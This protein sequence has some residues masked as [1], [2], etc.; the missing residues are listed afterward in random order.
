MIEQLLADLRSEE[1]FR[2]YAYDDATAEPIVPGYVMKGH[3]TIWHG[4]CIEKGRI[5]S[6]PA[7]VSDDILEQVASAIVL[8]ALDRWPWLID[9][10]ENTQRGVAQM[11]YQL[12]VG[13][14]AKFKNMLGALQAGDLAS[15]KEHALDS[16]WAR[17][18]APERAL[19]VASLIA[20][21]SAKLPT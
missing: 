15:A 17:E 9:L 12:G 2:A 6:I 13:G 21:E 10:P 20:N 5:P 3:P 14:V 4:L 7:R 1:G 8:Q 18:D 11:C 16:D 19:R